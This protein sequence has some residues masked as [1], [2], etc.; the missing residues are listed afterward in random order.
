MVQIFSAFPAHLTDRIL[1]YYVNQ[2]DKLQSAS[3]IGISGWQCERLIFPKQ[4]FLFEAIP[5]ALLQIYAGTTVGTVL[6]E[7]IPCIR[8]QVHIKPDLSEY[9]SNHNHRNLVE[10]S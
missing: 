9:P 8:L 1:C 4:R 5:Q 10:Q 2:T 7:Q 3:I 6:L